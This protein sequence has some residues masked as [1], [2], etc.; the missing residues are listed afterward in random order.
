MAIKNPQPHGVRLASVS[1]LAEFRL[2][3]RHLN[4]CRARYIQRHA[5]SFGLRLYDRIATNPTVSKAS[6][7]KFQFG[8]PTKKASSAGNCRAGLHQT[9]INF[10]RDGLNSHRSHGSPTTAATPQTMSQVVLVSQSSVVSSNLEPPT[11]FLK[12]PADFV[13]LKPV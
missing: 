6:V 10:V 11:K 3:S 4:F 9:T 8:E 12:L 2:I 1:T 13:E 5:H 7:M